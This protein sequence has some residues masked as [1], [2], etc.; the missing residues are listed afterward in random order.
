MTMMIRDFQIRVMTMILITTTHGMMIH[1]I[2][3][4]IQEIHGIQVA[5][6]GVVI[7]NDT[8]YRNDFGNNYFYS[9]YKYLKTPTIC[10]Q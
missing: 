3:V 5:E 6:T 2:P 7:G 10:H 4:G 9:D 8:H 1:G